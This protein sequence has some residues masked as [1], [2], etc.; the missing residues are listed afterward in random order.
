MTD[1]RQCIF[2]DANIIVDSIENLHF[3]E[4]ILTIPK[5]E[6][7]IVTNTYA[8]QEALNVIIRKGFT[9]TDSLHNLYHASLS[10]FDE[11]I[12]IS[13]NDLELAIDYRKRKIVN[14]NLLDTLHIVSAISNDCSVFYTKDMQHKHSIGDEILILN[15]YL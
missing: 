11:I 3:S 10:L 8:L 2:Y 14:Y 7:S 13:L 15:P 1:N 12:E 4:S 9:S 6:A 5:G